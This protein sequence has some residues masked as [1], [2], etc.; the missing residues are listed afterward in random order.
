MRLFSGGIPL[1]SV[2]SKEDS[3][4]VRETESGDS[5]QQD[6]L[7]CTGRTHDDQV[8]TLADS[9][10]DIVKAEFPQRKGY[11]LKRDHDSYLPAVR[12]THRKMMNTA[13]Q[14]RIMMNA[15]LRLSASPPVVNRW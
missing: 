12:V 10:I 3:P 9:E 7:T 15:T 4:A 8:F 2:P 13:I 6:R 11:L 1:A 14:M 5:F